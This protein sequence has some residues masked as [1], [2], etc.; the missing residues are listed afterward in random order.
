M[1]EIGSQLRHI[2]YRDSHALTCTHSYHKHKIPNCTKNRGSATPF[3]ALDSVYSFY[4]ANSCFAA[5]FTLFTAP[6]IESLSFRFFGLYLGLVGH[7]FGHDLGLKLG[8]A[9]GLNLGLVGL[10]YTW[11]VLVLP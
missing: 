2:Q 3:A 6:L 5:I 8:L 11:D 9:L 10:D 7:E 4:R 1:A